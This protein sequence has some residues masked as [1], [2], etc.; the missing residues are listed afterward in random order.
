M[1]IAFGTHCC[2]NRLLNYFWR[3]D[4]YIYTYFKH[5][6]TSLQSMKKCFGKTTTTDSFE[7]CSWNDVC[8]PNGE[9]QSAWS[10]FL[11]AASSQ[12]K[13]RRT[14][15]PLSALA[16]EWITLKHWMSEYSLG[17]FHYAPQ[18]WCLYIA[19][20]PPFANGWPSLSVDPPVSLTLLYCLCSCMKEIVRQW[21]S[22]FL[23]SFQLFNCQMT[24][25]RWLELH[26]NRA[27]SNC[28]SRFWCWN[29]PLPTMWTKTFVLIMVRTQQAFGLG[30]RFNEHIKVFQT[31][32]T[33]Q[34]LYRYIW[35]KRLELSQVWVPA[36]YALHADF[37]HADP[38]FTHTTSW[39]EV[40]VDLTR[41][42]SET[43]N[44]Q[45]DEKGDMR[46]KQERQIAASLHIT[47]VF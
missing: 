30:T 37:S 20:A 26:R 47:R 32:K 19:S 25:A 41:K 4:I 7:P 28:P 14:G 40:W 24:A 42:D 33:S 23:L 5:I 46:N 18:I 6:P 9:V 36:W 17:L 35:C 21:P 8:S 34:S 3:N 31:G 12:A 10:S 45:K 16:Y 22:W 13:W 11:L 43:G 44:G 39:R 15:E 38:S 2:Y 29:N 27:M 1:F